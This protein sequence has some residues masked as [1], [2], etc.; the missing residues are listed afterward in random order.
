MN[1]ALQIGGSEHEQSDCRD[2]WIRQTLL[3]L[4]LEI[5]RIDLQDDV[6]YDPMPMFVPK[7]PL[8]SETIPVES[9]P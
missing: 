1:P 6:R 7:L 5:S 4:T 9:S 3:L 8:K 2:S